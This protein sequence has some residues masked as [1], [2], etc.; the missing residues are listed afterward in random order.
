MTGA[1]NG[2]ASDFDLEA[3]AQ[4]AAAEAKAAPFN[5][6]YKGNDYTVPPMKSWPAKAL[7]ALR[8]GDLDTALPLVLGDD[9]Y[10]KLT[11][12]GLTVGE[13]ELLF[14]KIAN[15]GGLG[16]LPNSSPPRRPN[17]TRT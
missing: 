13:L 5:F 14:D 7:P 9:A 16:D 2:A 1:R 8:D 12:A 4:A 11:E 10:V 6:T 15:A 17:S 3:A